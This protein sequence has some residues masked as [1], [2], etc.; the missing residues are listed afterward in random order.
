MSRKT[1][2]CYAASFGRQKKDFSR[3]IGENSAGTTDFSGLKVFTS[4]LTAASLGSP[5]C[6]RSRRCRPRRLL[7][8]KS[9]GKQWFFT[10][11]KICKNDDNLM[12]STKS[13]EEKTFF[14]MQKTIHH[15]ASLG[16]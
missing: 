16:R 13:F 6:I 14:P 10:V 7:G 15:Q 5:L 8:L 3:F 1:I 11:V 4:L 9:F 2:C 12:L